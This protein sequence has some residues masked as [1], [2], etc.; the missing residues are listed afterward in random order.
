[1]RI[2]DGFR[3]TPGTY[4]I[5]L[6]AIGKLVG[7]ALMLLLTF[8]PPQVSAQDS[9]PTTE[10]NTIH[11]VVINA[12]THE[13]ISRALVTSSDNRY[14]TFTD[15]E[16]HFAFTVPKPASENESS[17]SPM[18][19]NFRLT[20]AGRKPGY[21]DDRD[22]GKWVEA[23]FGSEVT[24]ALMPEG[25]I[26]G[27]VTSP[28][29]D[30]VRGII[31]QLF[32][33][34][35]EDGNPRWR[36]VNT[37]TANS[38][39]EFRFA[40]L[41]P[42]T[43]K[44]CTRELL[45]NDPDTNTPDGPKYGYPPVYFPN[46][47]DFPSSSSIQL[48]AGQDFNAN[49][50]LVRQPYYQVKIPVA[51][52]E[53]Y[54]G[55]N[56]NVFLQ[57]QRGPGYSLGYN[58][59]R[60][61]IE[62]LLP[63][64]KYVVEATGWARPGT[65]APNMQLRSASGSANLT[66]A[67]AAAEGPTMALTHNNSIV[68]NVREQFNSTEEPSPTILVNDGKNTFS[69]RGARA[70]VNVRAEPVDEF[71]SQQG[72]FVRPPSGPDD[73]SLVLDNIGPGK[74]WLRVNATRGYVASATMGGSDLLREP[75]A[76]VPGANSQI[77]ITLRDDAAEIEGH[78]I[79]PGSNAESNEPIPRAY[80]YC[81]P[82][83]DSTGQFLDL[84]SSPDGSFDYQQVTP[85]AYRVIAFDSAQRDI[86]YRDPEAMRAYESKGQVVHVAP[87]EKVSLQLQPIPG[88]E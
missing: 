19:Q 39:G 29:G 53:E 63:D 22:Q 77:D 65:T 45:D 40:E 58:R 62:G 15:S 21:L 11:G 59:L 13:A 50:S 84:S 26:K 4:P 8:H 75:L 7:A 5:L 68:I 49:L 47:A 3:N 87:G 37:A 14:A 48:T 28:S 88:I 43:Y 6:G 72:D 54:G 64:G 32:L 70:A 35:V 74:Y 56:V 81:L 9:S 16:G 78:L 52:A 10:S 76:V 60:Q 30:S 18:I 80:I 12:I 61:Q 86:A 46:A 36:M 38:K 82:L 51:N 33:R 41:R 34:Q 1:M 69:L 73:D 20:L 57:G 25:L 83:P 27:R 2:A 55:L 42:G 67:G 23:A 17:F 85:G 66:V 79:L 31:V 71:G 24:I 44:L